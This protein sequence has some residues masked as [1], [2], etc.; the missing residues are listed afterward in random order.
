[1]KNVFLIITTIGLFSHLP[2]VAQDN[3]AGHM[4]TNIQEKMSGNTIVPQDNAVVAN[5]II[6]VM[7]DALKCKF[8]TISL[9]KELKAFASVKDVM[10]SDG[11]IKILLHK[12]MD[13][14][15]EDLITKLHKHGIV[16]DEIVRNKNNSMK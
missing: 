12:E 15:N 8:C 6:T 1:M 3:V 10:F 2:L 7:F 14:K 13:L 16:V 11:K 9:E 5:S 4:T